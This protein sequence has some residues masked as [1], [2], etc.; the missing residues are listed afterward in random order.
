MLHGYHLKS[1]NFRSR[2][3]IFFIKKVMKGLKNCL[4]A[5]KYT[6]L[7]SDTNSAYE[8]WR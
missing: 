4:S 2:Y 1:I 3:I 7:K 5:D 6:Y 8:P